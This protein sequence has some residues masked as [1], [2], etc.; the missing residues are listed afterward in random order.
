MSNS[1][2]RRIAVVILPAW[3]MWVSNSL[4]EQKEMINEIRLS[5]VGDKKSP[6]D[7]NEANMGQKSY[8]VH[9][10]NKYPGGQVRASEDAVDV[11]DRYGNHAVALRK[12]G[13]GQWADHSEELGCK[14]RHDLSPIPKEVRAM[15]LYPNGKVGPAEEHAERAPKGEELALQHGGKVPSIEEL[16]AHAKKA[17]AE[18]S[19]APGGSN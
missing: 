1:F 4:I 5:L 14:D 16:D 3:C 10:R 6:N 11:Y 8:Y 19:S 13:S 2:W 15:K 12:N 7:E 9:Y 18:K 17:A